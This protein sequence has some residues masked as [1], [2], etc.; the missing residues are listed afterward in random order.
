[1][2][3]SNRLRHFLPC[4]QVTK[5]AHRPFSASIPSRA[6]NFNQPNDPLPDRKKPNVSATNAVPV[7]S[8]GA[9]DAPIQEVPEEGERQ[10]QMQA[11]NRKTTWAP[12]QQPR[13]KAM[14]GPRFEQTIMEFQVRQSRLYRIPDCLTSKPTVILKLIR[15]YSSLNRMLPLS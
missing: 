6:E 8:V 12:S 15:S 4:S 7:S 13:E 11:P 1:M 14:V 9:R 5:L 2:Y 3:T 10:R